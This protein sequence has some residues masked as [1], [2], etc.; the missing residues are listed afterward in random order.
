[1]ETLYGQ[2]KVILRARS[3][4]KKNSYFSIDIIL[5][6]STTFHA[7]C[8]LE[9]TNDTNMFNVHHLSV[10]QKWCCL[11]ET[12]NFDSEQENNKHIIISIVR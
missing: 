6:Y 9:H 10:S 7:E 3:S 2:Q 1:V 12:C 11:M 5:V 8:K 4:K